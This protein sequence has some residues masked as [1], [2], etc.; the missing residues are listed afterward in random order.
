MFDAQAAAN[1]RSR[2]HFM[3]RYLAAKWFIRHA[4]FEE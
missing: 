3:T 4:P 2:V 1:P